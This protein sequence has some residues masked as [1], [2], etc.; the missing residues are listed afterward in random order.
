[1]TK[2]T[3]AVSIPIEA[4]WTDIREGVRRICEQ[5]PNAYWVK[6]DHESAYPLR[7]HP[8][9]D[10]RRQEGQ[11]PLRRQRPEGVDVPRAAV[12]PDA[13]ACPHHAARQGEEALRWALRFPRRSARGQGERCR[14]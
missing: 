2:T 10:T 4:G 7:H 3:E 14:D 5:Y 13:A 8:A 6:L 1:M 12:R 9:Q 11:R